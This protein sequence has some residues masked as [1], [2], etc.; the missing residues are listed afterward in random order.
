MYHSALRAELSSLGLSWDVPRSGLGEIAG[1]PKEV[2]RAFSKRRGD[3]EKALAERGLDSARAAE[4]AALS[5]RRAKPE[6]IGATETLRAGWEV[7]LAQVRIRDGTGIRAASVDDVLGVVGLHPE[8]HDPV[9]REALFAV[10]AG[11]HG[12][13]LSDY[14]LDDRQAPGPPR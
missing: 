11:E 4:V 9:E 2:L 3:I 7:E 1:V 13:S 5:T 10:L 12:V 6:V 14:D 8:D